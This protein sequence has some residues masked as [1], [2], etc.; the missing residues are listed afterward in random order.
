[1]RL[2]RKL[3]RRRCTVI[4]SRTEARKSSKPMPS[5]P[6]WRNPSTSVPFC[7]A[8]LLIA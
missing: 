1:M 8:M 4:S 3:W 2:C 5:G 6:A 7:W